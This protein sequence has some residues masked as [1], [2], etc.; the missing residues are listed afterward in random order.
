MSVLP[1][2][3]SELVRAAARQHPTERPAPVRRM[4]QGVRVLPAVFALT[5]TAAIA[6]V[7]VTE[8]RHRALRPQKSPVASGQSQGHHRT[9]RAV[10]SVVLTRRLLKANGI[11]NITFG[12]DRGTAVAGLERLLGPPHETIPGICGFGRSTDWIGLNI[13]SRNIS[14]AELNLS[15]KHSRFVGY[16]YS[17][18]AEGPAR[19]RQG[20]LLA[21]ARGLAL[22]DSVARARHLY[23]Q[24]FVE[25]RVPQ[26]TPPSAKL[27]RL[28]VGQVSTPSGK[29]TVGIQGSGRG[30]RVSAHSTLMSISAGEGPNTPCR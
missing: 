19:Q 11:G 16:A 3:R 27:P 9:S 5:V 15:F 25:T 21:T 10:P 24:A 20:I 22:G 23:G 30:D 28:P 18:N 2:L 14:S 4:W 29:I 17:A 7:T 26:G 6:V 8:L 1:N 13:H 12:Q